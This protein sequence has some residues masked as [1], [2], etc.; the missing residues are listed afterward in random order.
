[1]ELADSQSIKPV[2]QYIFNS[3]IATVFE[4]LKMVRWMD[5]V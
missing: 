2:A 3:D 1:M 5:D 4:A